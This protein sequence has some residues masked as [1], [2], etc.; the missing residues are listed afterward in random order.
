MVAVALTLPL[1]LLAVKVYVVVTVGE[2]GS[3]PFNGTLP[4]LDMVTVVAPTVD[5]DRVADWP[6]VIDVGFAT[7]EAMVGP[8]L[9][10][11]VT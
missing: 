4:M 7:K 9:D 3:V 1:A 11:V 2:T 5:Q 8:V 10:A 6:A